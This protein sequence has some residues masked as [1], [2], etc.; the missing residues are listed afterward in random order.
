MQNGLEEP[1]RDEANLDSTVQHMNKDMNR[2][3]HLTQ[4]A[5]SMKILRSKYD[6]SKV[7][8]QYFKHTDLRDYITCNILQETAAQKSYEAKLLQKMHNST[9]HIDVIKQNN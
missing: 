4:K 3:I 1:D 9:E 6:T 2:Q 8:T 5:K 7:S